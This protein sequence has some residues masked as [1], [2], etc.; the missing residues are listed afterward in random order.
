MSVAADPRQ[1]RLFQL[2]PAIYR[3]RDQ[4]NGFPLRALLRVIAG[5]VNVV[6]DDIAQLYNNWFIETCQDWVVPYIGDLIGW[7]LAAGAGL[8]GAS[9]SDQARNRV[10]MPRREIANLIRYR[11]RKG[12]LALI[13]ELAWSVAG[14]PARAVEFD[15]VL[16]AA[17]SLNHLHLDRGRTLDLRCG[18][19]LDRL[20]GPF[21]SAARVADIRRPNSKYRVGL[22]NLPGVGLY[23]WRLRS[24]PLRFAPAAC[25]EEVD[26]NC[27]TFSVLGHDSPLFNQPVAQADPTA[28]AGRP[29]VPA[30]IRRRELDTRCTVHGRLRP[31]ASASYYGEDKSF[32]IW[33]M[34]AQRDAGAAK[35]GR[36]KY[37]PQLVPRESIVVA[38]LSDWSYLPRRGTVAVDPELGRMRFAEDETPKQGVWV[39]YHYG[40]SADIGGGTYPRPILQPAAEP[41][42]YFRVNKGGELES[43]EAALHRWRSEPSPPLRAVI[44]IADN[45]VYTER[46]RIELRQ[47]ENLQIRAANGFRPVVR[48]LD[49][50]V[51]GPDVLVVQGEAGTRFALDGI[52]VSGRNIELGGDLSEAAIRHCTLV[53]GWSLHC[54]CEPK[55]PSEPSIDVLAPNICIEISHSIVGR[56]QVRPDVPP[57]EGQPGQTPQESVIQSARCAGIGPGVRL[58]PISIRISD[59]IVD[60]T[61]DT[62]EAIGAPGCPVAHA[63]LEISRCTIFG[64]VEAHTIDLG[65]DSIFT[66]KITVARRQSGCLRFCSVVPGSRTPRR[67]RCLPDLVDGDPATRDQ[68]RAR[69]RPIFRSVRYGDPDYAR[70]SDACA[71]ELLSGAHD[72][73][74]MGVFHDLFQ[75]QR[76]ALLQARLDEFV[77]AATDAGVLFAD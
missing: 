57:V 29:N 27:F 72:E 58:D 61:S 62:R 69:V 55:R 43:I 63:R 2:L 77:P 38:D 64:R 12:T 67:Y 7:Q 41:F 9:S 33:R 15:R 45:A 30:R 66:G 21:D 10:I 70:L 18:A 13:E 74:E 73:S 68:E 25:I 16:V 24:Y 22:Y 50:R 6:E 59:S 5:Q 23:V 71:P 35:T 20:G 56:I 14:W 51:E 60:A 19:V 75:A 40:F 53:P 76:L 37:V 3:I 65:E 36:P 17:Q 32:V 26:P 34:V 28:I 49:W 47:G 48:L 8:P 42:A 4:E 39:Y 54:E 31:C 46:L 52:V 11:R 44:E 1:D